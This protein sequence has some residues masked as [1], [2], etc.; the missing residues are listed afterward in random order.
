MIYQC[1][2]NDFHLYNLWYRVVF[3]YG[4]SSIPSYNTVDDVSCV[5]SLPC[6]DLVDA[7]ALWFGFCLFDRSCCAFCFRTYFLGQ[8]NYPRM[9]YQLPTG[10]I[11]DE[12]NGGIQ[13]RLKPA[14]RIIRHRRNLA[15][16]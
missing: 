8:Q 2:E 15:R 11:L 5:F 6:R 7:L 4:F 10:R 13:N 12:G 16:Q 1:Y 14:G 3:V 9:H